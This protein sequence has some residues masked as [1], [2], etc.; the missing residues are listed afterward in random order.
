VP[1]IRSFK[2][3]KTSDS[4]TESVRPPTQTKSLYAFVVAQ[5]ALRT[6]WEIFAADTPGLVDVVVFNGMVDTINP[7]TGLRVRPCLITIRTTRDTFARLELTQ[8]EPLAC[9]KHLSA[10]VSKSPAELVPVRPVLEFSMLDPRFVAESDAISV[11]DERPNLLELTPTEFEVLIQNLFTKMGLEA[12]QTRASRD[13]ESTASPTTRGRSLEAR[14]SSKP[15][16]TRTPSASPQ[17]ATF[18][19]PRRTRA[20]PRASL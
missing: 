10:G 20:D 17:S 14:L 1:E 19:A 6:I 8:V 5:I 4:V 7:G 2:Y 3:V 18:S 9:L 15:S 11:L 16:A 13:G 12:K